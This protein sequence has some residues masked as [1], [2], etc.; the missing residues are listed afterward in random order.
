MTN[1]LPLRRTRL[2]VMSLLMVM[3]II[4]SQYYFQMYRKYKK[5]QDVA[6]N[7]APAGVKIII[8]YY[9]AKT[10]AI[11][12]FA[13]SDVISC[14]AFEIAMLLIQDMYH[15][16]PKCIARRLRIMDKTFSTSTLGFQTICLALSTIFLVVPLSLFTVFAFT[17]EAKVVIIKDG[18][19]LDCSAIAPLDDLCLLVVYVEMP[20]SERS[21]RISGS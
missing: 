17:K 11:I 7:L 21:V 1:N 12:V 19:A 14:I 10:I 6:N 18:V 20:Y 8:D 13:A 3:C 16:I 9:D 5:T 4:A 2:I 15:T